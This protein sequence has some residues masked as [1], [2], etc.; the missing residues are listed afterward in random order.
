MIVW[1]RV[2]RVL[3]WCIWCVCLLKEIV[4]C[5]VIDLLSVAVWF[6]IVV[7]FVCLCVV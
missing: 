2:V 4:A 7:L 3:L 1:L 5:F 6:G